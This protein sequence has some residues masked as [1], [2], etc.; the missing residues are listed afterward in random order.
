MSDLQPASDDIVISPVKSGYLVGRFTDAS[1][2][3]LCATDVDALRFAHRHACDAQVDVWYH[4]DDTAWRVKRYR[5]TDE[6]PH[7]SRTES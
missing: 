2:S 6:L 3:M 1:F 5:R 7:T 4:D